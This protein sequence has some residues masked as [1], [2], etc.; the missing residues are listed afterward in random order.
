MGVP[1]YAELSE[2]LVQMV[3]VRKAA[4]M[5]GV[6][7]ARVYELVR[8]S[9][10]RLINAGSRQSYIPVPDIEKYAEERKARKTTPRQEK[11]A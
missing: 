2:G 9:R 5:L 10:L 1:F 8:E 4:D 3:G 6:T 11:V 7:R